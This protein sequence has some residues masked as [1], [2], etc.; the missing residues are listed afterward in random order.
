[1]VLI[2][3]HVES[4][5]KQ[6][7]NTSFAGNVSRHKVLTKNVRALVI[8][9]AMGCEQRRRKKLENHSLLIVFL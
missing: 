9:S 6:I 2:Q 5:M 7:P 8:Q 3:I 4:L 1:M